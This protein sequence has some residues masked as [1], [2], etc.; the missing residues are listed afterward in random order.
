MDLVQLIKKNLG[1]C[2]VLLGVVEWLFIDVSGQR[3][4]H[5]TSVSK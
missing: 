1:Y 2:A 3:I 4:G 5:R